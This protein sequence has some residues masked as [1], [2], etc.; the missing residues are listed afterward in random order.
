M[1]KDIID[2]SNTIIYK[3]YCIDDTIVDTYVGH[4]T[5]FYVRKYQHKNACNNLKNVL[6]IYKIIRENGGWDNWNMIEIAKYN[7]NDS[8]EA[9]I[10]EQL[11]Y[12]ELKSTLN[13]CPPYVDKKKYFCIDCN[14][15]CIGP[16]HFNNHITCN[17]HIKHNKVNLENEKTTKTTIN[18]SKNIIC[19]NCEMCE[20]KCSKK[21]DWTRHIMSGK[22]KN[23]MLTTNDTSTLTKKYECDK[24]NKNF[25]DRA[26]L[27]RHNKKCII[28][29]NS[30]K[31]QNI[32]VNIADLQNED[33]QQQLIEYLL[34][35]NSE[36]KQLMIDQNKQLFEL[37]KNS[38]NHNSNNTI[39]TT[40][41]N[42]FNLQFFLNETCK[43][44]MNIM[45]FVDQL[46]VS[47]KDLEETGR[48]GYTEGISKIFINGLKQ[49]NISDRPIHC[50]DSKREI[51]YIKDKNQW[52]KEDDNKS[53]LTNAIKHV[54][55]KNMRQIREWTKVNPEYND[56][57]SKQNDRYLKIVSNSMN[58]STEE[59][60]N[61][62]YNK[63]IKN[64]TKE[65]VIDK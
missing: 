36:F 50:S 62:N 16:N 1:P 3:I 48:L 55:H 37:A 15:Q 12:E 21:G 56:S 35:E 58:G 57:S 38:G 9:R 23:N 6:K 29:Q 59:E 41:N 11:H 47:V 18:T 40:N 31:P 10:K 5:N 43:D 52:N 30:G 49:I 2:Y 19:F 13:S 26:G 28:I 54:A 61:K 63:I 46:Q 4:T 65:T 60:T 14:L 53:L 39:N 7:C 33:K 17:L 45:E 34:K 44:A 64:I 32:I 8:T 24:C 22:H 42:N 51:V 20:F 27:W 25:N